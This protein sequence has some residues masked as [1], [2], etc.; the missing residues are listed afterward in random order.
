MAG[1]QK[2]I[3]GVRAEEH[4]GCERTRGARAG[5]HNWWEGTRGGRHVVSMCPNH[6]HID[7]PP[8][9]HSENGKRHL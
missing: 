9:L 3:R 7:S 8:H 1:G 4:K 2:G 5:G 6:P